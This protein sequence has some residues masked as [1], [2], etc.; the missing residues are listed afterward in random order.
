LVYLVVAGTIGA[1]FAVSILRG[2]M[3]NLHGM[4]AEFHAL[5]AKSFLLGKTDLPIAPD[6]RLIALPDP[7]DPKANFEYRLHDA[8]LYKGKYYIYFG[9]VPTLVLFLPF[10]AATGA[11]LQNRVA[12]PVFCA[13]GFLCSLGAF[14]S[15]ARRGKWMVP[16]WLET[17]VVVALGTTSVA[18]V[19]R[20]PLFYEVAISSGYAF[21]MAGILA[22]VHA[23]GKND[24]AGRNS[25]LLSGLFFGMAAGCRPHL[26]LVAAVMLVY[27]LLRAKSARISVVLFAAPLILCAVLLMLYNYA[28]FDS[29]LE[30]GRNYQ[31]GAIV[32]D[33]TP[34]RFGRALLMYLF[35]IPTITTDFPFVHP[36]LIYTLADRVPTVWDYDS[37]IG[38][39]TG[40]PIVVFGLCA[41]FVLRKRYFGAPD[42]AGAIRSLVSYLC[43]AAVLVLLFVSTSGLVIGRYTVDFVPMLVLGGCCAITVLW[44][45]VRSEPARAVRLFQI[46]VTAAVAWSALLNVAIALPRLDLIRKFIG[47]Q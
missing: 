14:Y 7:Y 29:V 45:S 40:F 43:V 23:L 9:P 13:I 21:V 35:A 17:A 24:R 30:F 38:L 6:P 12:V 36:C 11:D 3:P 1:Y 42:V 47:L 20:R 15:L 44:Q 28:R 16:K 10:R 41:H 37:I 5:L 2:S 32:Q 4:T 31:V 22:L 26:A 33:P 46:S 19:L 39:V 27:L 25:I 18:F 34:F 8:S